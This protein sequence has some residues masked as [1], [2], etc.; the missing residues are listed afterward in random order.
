MVLQKS[1]NDIISRETTIAQVALVIVIILV[2]AIIGWT[3][4]TTKDVALATVYVQIGIG[5][6]ERAFEGGITEGMTVLGAIDVATT[7]GKIDFEY[8]LS[9][10]NQASILNIGGHRDSFEIYLN[11]KKLTSGEVDKT[12][13][14]AGDRIEIKI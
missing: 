7:T 9:K 5:G 11:S 4:S 10:N 13:V 2:V 3:S 12:Q 1:S 8:D 6:Q 14:R